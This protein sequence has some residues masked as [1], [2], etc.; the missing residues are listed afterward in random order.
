M[1]VL[2]SQ[3]A[4]GQ[5][6]LMR[7]TWTRD[8]QYGRR[9]KATPSH[10]EGTSRSKAGPFPSGVGTTRGTGVATRQHPRIVRVPLTVR[11]PL[12]PPGAGVVRLGARMPQQSLTL[13]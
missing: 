10:S 6:R 5:G 2:R 11:L 4:R 9:G 13:A 1:H 3:G 7:V 8:S 12:L